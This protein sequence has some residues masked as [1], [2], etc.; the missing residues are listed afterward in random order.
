[1]Y[2]Y[3]VVTPPEDTV[4]R[5]WER[6]LVRGRYKSVEDFLGHCIEAY[7]GMPKLLFKWLANSRPKFIFEFLDNSVAKG[8]YPTMIARGTQAH[9]DIFD[10][11]AFINIERYRKI[12]VM[13]RTAYAIYPAQ[14]VLEVAKNIGFL[15]QCIRKIENVRF[16]DPESGQVYVTV[17]SGKFR[18]T[19]V[20]LFTAKLLS[21]DLSSIFL[22]LAPEICSINKSQAS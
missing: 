9:I 6:G 15:Q 20:G 10:P 16:L 17:T 19:D 1:M 5:G 21:T 7:A 11:I 13:A 4:E 12:N 8:H 22:Q 3:F 2:M 18:V 14:Q